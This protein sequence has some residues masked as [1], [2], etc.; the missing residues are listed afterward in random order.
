MALDSRLQIS[1]TQI[2]CRPPFLAL[3]AALL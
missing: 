1:G 3:V 2:L